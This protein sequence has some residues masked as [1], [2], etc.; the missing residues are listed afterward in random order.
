MASAQTTNAP[1]GADFRSFR[2][3]SERNIFNASRS[4]QRPSRGGRGQRAAK[5]DYFKLLGTMS[6]EKGRFAIFGGSSAQFRKTIQPQEFISQYKVAD[7]GPS[8][9]KLTTTNGQVIEM[10]VGMQIRRQDNGPWAVS[11]LPEPAPE[12]AVASASSTTSENSPTGSSG[13]END[14]LKRLMQKREQ[15]LTK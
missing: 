14:V 1:S 6:Y 13:A 3:I 5:I 7:I 2:I 12:S 11:N 8:S 15:E 9:I 4:G 10:R